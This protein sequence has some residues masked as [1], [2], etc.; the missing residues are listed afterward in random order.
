M[1]KIRDVKQSTPVGSNPPTGGS[2]ARIADQ[3]RDLKEKLRELGRVRPLRD[4]VSTIEHPLTGPQL[5]SLLWL[6][7]EGTLSAS[8]LAQRVGCGQPSITGVIDRL[9][10]LGYAQRA[11]DTDDR[12]VVNVE[13]T[14]EGKKLYVQLDDRIT[15]KMGLF[16]SL[17]AN[18]DRDH[19][20][21]IIG[22]VIEVLRATAMPSAPAEE[23]T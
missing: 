1:A 4:P 13:L 6:G 23:V 10:K 14:D 22:N 18:D 12:R 21:R 16:L 8:V 19:L 20:I 11:R 17:L 9:E 5:H 3:V 7:T 2:D 15:D